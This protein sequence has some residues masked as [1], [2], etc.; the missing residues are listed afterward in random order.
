MN[1]TPELTDDDRHP[2]EAY[3]ESYAQMERVARREG[4]PAVVSMRS[5]Y[6][7]IRKNM[8]PATVD[9]AVLDKLRQGGEPVGDMR[10]PMSKY[11]EPLLSRKAGMW[12]AINV[13]EDIAL[14]Y[15][16]EDDSSTNSTYHE[17]AGD[18]LDKAENAIR[19]LLSGLDFQASAP[20]A[21]SNLPAFESPAVQAVYELL[22]DDQRPP[23]GEHWE[24]FVA[25]RIVQ[26]L[27]APVAG[28]ARP[29]AVLAVHKNGEI[30]SYSTGQAL[31][32]APIQDSER[33][34]QRKY[35]Y[36]LVTVYAAPQASADARNAALEE[37]A[38]TAYTALF[39]S[40]ARS[41]WTEF[42]ESAAFHA[43]HAAQC[44][45]ALMSTPAPQP[46]EGEVVLPPLPFGLGMMHG[47]Q[48]RAYARAAVLA[49]RQ[50]RA[51]LSAAQ[52][53]QGEREDG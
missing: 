25:R 11:D 5:V 31:Q 47:E 1:N 23:I 50:Q 22:C 35:G 18:A 3:A 7:D 45:R 44:I 14:Q 9:R 12:L 16:I 24:G 43:K 38:Q 19:A 36:E 49:D 41:D 13:I 4:K 26:R 15:R 42:A 34:L 29:F 21:V 32:D 30:R 33:E 37:A 20:A 6:W 2:L 51:A 52:T 48:Y 27:S 39:P 28:E 10:N 40:N 46:A 53:E 17:G 8:I